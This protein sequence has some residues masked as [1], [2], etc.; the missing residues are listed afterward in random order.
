[1]D[2]FLFR[3]DLADLDPDVAALA[4]LEALRQAKKL[5]LIPSESSVPASVR[6]A[7]ASAFHNIYA[8]GY[9]AP[10]RGGV[11]F[12]VDIVKGGGHRLPH[13]GRYAGLG[14]DEDQF[15][16]LA[17]RF[18]VGESGNIWIEIGEVAAK[19]KVI[20]ENSSSK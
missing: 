17:Q 2:D 18:Q 13:R 16:G 7:V 11:A 19:E 10:F 1:M 12:G 8:E 14:R 6:Q 3:G 9:P 4:D 5:I 20:H 15:F